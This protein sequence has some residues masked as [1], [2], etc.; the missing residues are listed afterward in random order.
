[1]TAAGDV[2]LSRVAFACRR[3]KARAHPLDQRLGLRPQGWIDR[4]RRDALRVRIQ[5]PRELWWWLAAVA[6]ALFAAEVALSRRSRAWPSRTAL[7]GSRASREGSRR[8]DGRTS[9]R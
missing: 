2:T 9:A 8:A 6:A 5:P 3:C 1:M 4:R 7:G